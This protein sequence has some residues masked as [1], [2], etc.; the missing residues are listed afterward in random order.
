[1][2]CFTIVLLAIG[3]VLVM[4]TLLRWF[5]QITEAVETRAWGKVV[6]LLVMP[7]PVQAPP[8]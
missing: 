1:M 6:V 3:F 8:L 5:D 2:G 7:L 4:L